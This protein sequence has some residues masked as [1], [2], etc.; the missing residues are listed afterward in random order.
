VTT[1]MAIRHGLAARFAELP[2]RRQ[3]LIQDS[4]LAIALAVVNVLSLLPER[5]RLHPLWLALLLVAGQA[6]PLAFRR[7]LAIPAGVVIGACRVGYDV[8][9]FHFAPFPLG[10]AIIVYTVFDQCGL[11]ARWFTCALL[12]AGISVSGSA[13]GHSEPYDALIQVFIFAAAIGAGL[14]SRAMRSSLRAE[15]RRADRA[16][17][18]LDEQ[19]A[20]AAAAE[21]ARIA[22]ELH[23]V[24]AHH[25]SLMAVQAE[26]AGAL[27]PGRPEEAA[28]SVNVIGD[29]ARTALTE[30]RRLLGVLRGPSE[31]LDTAPAAS[32]SE[33]ADVLATV[34]SAG[35]PV[36]FEVTGTP[37]ALAPGVE[38]AAYRIV[39]EALT[40]TLRHSAAERACVTVGYEPGFVTLSVTDA[41]PRRG[42]APELTQRGAAPELTQRGAAPELTQRGAAPELTQRGAAP[43]PAQRRSA[44]WLPPGEAAPIPHGGE[45]PGRVPRGEADGRSAQRRATPARVADGET[46]RPV[47]VPAGPGFGLAG[48]AERVASCGGSLTVGPTA[49]AGFAVTA[50]LPVR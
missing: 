21:R 34:R 12:A 15:Q 1:L 44:H 19:A 32:L 49:A 30:L 7:A 42:A 23:D 35:L 8:A 24:V 2:A 37:A 50:R 48:I 9:G 46:E 45:A 38:L 40:N 4:G 43:R 18:E 28:S 13:P 17:A 31:R 10:P 33:L 14:L 6:L 5:S 25:V 39:Q 20:R 11:V 29:T 16:E 26:A 41:G 36:D 27:L 3:E 22:R 47:L